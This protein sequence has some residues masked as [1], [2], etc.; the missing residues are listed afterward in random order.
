MKLK[1]PTEQEKRALRGDN[2]VEALLYALDQRMA[3][4]TSVII[5][6]RASYEVGD[7]EFTQK[8]KTLLG[9]EER[10]SEI[11]GKVF[12]TDDIDC[13]HTDAAQA[14][15]DAA[16]Q[17]SYLAKMADCYVHAL[18]EQT[19]ILPIGWQ[20][21]LKPVPGNYENLELKRLDPLDFVICKGA[22][23]RP[24]DA[25]FLQAFCKALNI[26]REQVQ[27]KINETLAR[28]PARLFL[29][30][31]AQ[32]YLVMLPNK[33]FPPAAIAGGVVER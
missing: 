17:N 27:R 14:V 20:E 11:S 12:L 22:A 6:G 32:K 7:K 23:G 25:K 24:K 33:I 26:D 15:V 2:N 21:R 8:L 5:V 19:L 10:I 13:F 9:E 1:V 18:N 29:D 31:S 28:K 30:T 16:Y 4:K 3:E